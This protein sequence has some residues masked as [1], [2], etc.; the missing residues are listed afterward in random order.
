M[1]QEKVGNVSLD[2]TYYPGKDLYSDGEIEQT[3]LDIVSTV[4]EERLEQ[5][6]AARLDWSVLYHLSDVRENIVAALPIGKKDDVLEIGAGCGAITGQLARMAGSVTCVDL[7]RQ[8]SLINA[9]R[10]RM[11]DNIQILVGNFQD[12]EKS[13]TKQYDYITLIGVFEYAQ[14]YIGT[15]DPYA[16]F[17]R[18][19]RRH[20]KPGGRIVI[21][22][23]NRLG[24]KYWAGAREDHT[25][26]FFEGLENYPRGSFV[27]TFSRPELERIF[28][29]VGLK[30]RTF[31]YPYPDYKL[32]GTV[33]SDEILPQ[34]GSLNRNLYNFDRDRMLLFDEKAV[35]DSL[36]AG[37]QFPLFSNSYLV[38]LSEEPQEEKEKLLYS[39]YSTER[40]PRFALRT[41]IMQRGE[42]R[43]VVKRAALGSASAHIRQM[44]QSA[45]KLTKAYA[46]S[47]IHVNRLLETTEDAAVFAYLADEETME[48]HL[49]SLL[50][51][52]RENEAR[53]LL[54][55]VCSLIRSR[56]EEEFVMTD[57]F[58]E[59]FLQGGEKRGETSA[60][61]SGMK[62]AALT[63]LDMVAENLLMRPDGEWDLIDYEW[64]CDFPVPVDFVLYRI[65]HY[66]A[67][68]LLPGE[69]EEALLKA[70]GFSAQ[71]AERF[72]GWEQSWQQ[73]VRGSRTPLLDLYAA[74]SP[75]TVNVR[76][77]LSLQENRIEQSYLGSLYY[78]ESD[79]FTQEQRLS[80]VTYVDA[81]GHFSAQLPVDRLS[82][83]MH[84]RWDPLEQHMCRIRIERITADG[85]VTIVPN[86]GSRSSSGDE[87]LT[88]DPSYRILADLQHLQHLRIE[89]TLELL[90]LNGR[91]DQIDQIRQERD[92]YK[93]E[94][95]RL[96]AQIAAIHATKAYRMLEGMRRVRNY[97]QAR[98][99]GTKLFTNPDAGPKQYQD[100]LQEHSADADT[101]ASQRLTCLTVRPLISILV[102]VYRTPSVY[103][104]AM[105]ESVRSQTYD[106]WELC[107][108]DAS[109][110]D[111]DGAR[112]RDEKVKR[113]LEEY[114]AADPRI[115]V[116]FLESNLGISGN[117][118]AAADLAQGDYLALLDHDDLLAP[119]C[120]F[121]VAAEIGRSGA[122]ML[123]TDEDKINRLG[124]D[125]FAPNLK[126]DFA[127][128]LLR[129]HNYITHFL[130]VKKALF[131][132]AG[133]FHS[134]CD[135]AQDYDLILRCSEAAQHIA[136]IPKILYHW[137][138]HE[139]STAADPSSKMYA[140][141]AGKRALEGHLARTGR[142]GQVEIL[143]QWGMYH[144]HYDVPEDALVSVIIP[145]KDQ[146]ER[147][148]TCVQSIMETSD[149]K[150]LEV[151]IVENGS[152]E[153]K[154]QQTYDNLM[155]TYPQVK[156]VTYMDAFNYS[157]V[158]NFGVSKASGSYLLL[159]NNDTRLIEPGSIREMVGHCSR[160]ETGCVGAK[161][162]YPNG[163]VQH[164]GIVLGFGP[165]GGFAGHVFT[166]L[167]QT[168]PGFMSRAIVVNNYSAVT[169]A[170]LMVRREVYE[171]VGGL[172]PSFAVALNDV[173]FCLRVKEAGLLNV[174]TPFS[175]WYH[176]ESVT[177]GYEDTPEKKERFQSEVAAFRSRWHDTLHVG[178]PYYN[179]NFSL[180]R[181]PFTL[182]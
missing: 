128:D 64:C 66:Y 53:A 78:S 133:G 179:P 41:D 172:D 95:E 162:L 169:G 130:T 164:G 132:Q 105:I 10:H 173:D 30:G 57:A 16:E 175:L 91:L 126:P 61:C 14:G 113:I 127:P 120:L 11:Y 70:E 161:L 27:R 143:P 108:A 101:L 148:H 12:I 6:I 20:L 87:F 168:D 69:N 151:I 171:A 45:E 125:H 48:S 121:E 58:A 112:I 180:E 17:L 76:S 54:R 129:S 138:M 140:Y 170:C 93:T 5:E 136:H 182:W 116:V 62:C 163:T 71:L 119:D 174:W 156:V 115:H 55:E 72:A 43:V 73:Y 1:K 24:L 114:A 60:A 7:S 29:Q 134:E 123:Y 79:Q 75:G 111:K 94:T 65:W 36:T 74:I 23:E 137:R 124:S 81:D 145:N 155:Q 139:G 82:G 50:L 13:L 31:Y 103:L 100:W 42:Q 25:G 146:A 39:K 96:R 89:G 19:I 3:L 34:P 33:F 107:L 84:L 15:E 35:F 97:C 154:T 181:G 165:Y 104:R 160:P 21:A 177:R 18:Q 52:G 122:D 4:P 32:P 149:W 51:S 67:A 90:Y 22:I 8:R 88:L 102:P 63:D 80:A 157:A 110:E 77:E 83:R 152:T 106:N 85:A 49:R 26:N 147:L 38:I 144:I 44:A 142:S 176:D 2:Y 118:N 68:R 131:E 159:L 40:D 158:N 153:E 86:N 178:D 98:I 46:G 141:E 166:G 28:D 9:N 92:V 109:V 167:S 59:M 135:G 117:T 56:A 47:K 99:R 37:G 150:N